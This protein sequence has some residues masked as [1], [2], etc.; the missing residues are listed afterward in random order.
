MRVPFFSDPVEPVQEELLRAT[1]QNHAQP[2][3]I[4][5]GRVAIAERIMVLRQDT[6][7]P[8]R[9]HFTPRRLDNLPTRWKTIAVL[10]ALALLAIV[11]LTGTGFASGVFFWDHYTQGSILRKIHDQKR[12]ESIGQSQQ[13]GQITITVNWAYADLSN[14]LI[15]YDIQMPVS[16]ARQYNNIALGPYSLTDQHGHEPEGANVECEGLPH[17]GS[18]M[19]CILRAP[20]VNPGS[21]GTQLTFTFD[22]LG[23]YLIPP[24]P[25]SK[26]YVTG[27][28]SFRFTTPFNRTRTGP[29]PSLLKRGKPR[30]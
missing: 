16:M 24:P 19:H 6:P 8:Q 4:E 25:A 14:T 5:R 12:Y 15:A 20:A 26:E 10:T 2:V 29:P 23:L 22:I 17:D 3:D 27:T 11:I 21:G 28:W 1:L 13:V 30:K 18:P 9:N 7:I